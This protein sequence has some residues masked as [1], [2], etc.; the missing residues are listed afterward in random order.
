MRR[1]SHW[2]RPVQSGQCWRSSRRCSRW[3]RRWIRWDSWLRSR[4]SFP[5]RWVERQVPLVLEVLVD[6]PVEGERPREEVNPAHDL[7]YQ[8]LVVLHRQLNR[9]ISN[10]TT[11]YIQHHSHPVPLLIPHHN[12]YIPL[13]LLIKTRNYLIYSTFRTIKWNK[14]RLSW[15]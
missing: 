13:L 3:S 1:V 9:F 12:L 5:R 8:A 14:I 2:G 4:S 6:L 10:N 7:D 15:S 11:L